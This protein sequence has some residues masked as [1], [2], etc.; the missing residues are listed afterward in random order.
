PSDKPIYF[1]PADHADVLS[2]NPFLDSF[3]KDFDAILFPIDPDLVEDRNV[4]DI[5]QFMFAVQH[6]PQLFE[7][8][9]F[10]LDFK[11]RQVAGG[12]LYFQE[13]DWK[14]DPKYY[15]WFF[16]MSTQPHLLFFI[17]DHDA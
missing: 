5:Q 13:M 8:L 12:D 3:S 7:K 6:R 14:S 4:A 11:F 9:V 2:W 17:R 10:A 16:N 15:S 1:F